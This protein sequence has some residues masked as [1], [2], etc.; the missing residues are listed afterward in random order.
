MYTPRRLEGA[1]NL[2]P[3]THLV[4][5]AGGPGPP[6]ERIED[7]AVLPLKRLSIPKMPRSHLEP[8]I[9]STARTPRSPSGRPS[10]PPGQGT[11][12]RRTRLAPVG[13]ST[14]PDWES[15]E[16]RGLYPRLGKPLLRV[17]LFIATFPV[18]L[19]IAIP[20]AIVN[21]ILFGSPRHIVYRQRRVGFR[22]RTFIIYKF[23]TLRDSSE[24]E[25]DA[26]SEG[27]DLTRVT[28]FGLFLRTTHLDELPQL[29]NILRGEM[30]FIGPRPEMLEIDRWARERIPN[31]RERN[32]LQPG[33]T[34]YAQ[35]THGYAHR[36]PAAYAR[37]L[38]ADQHYRRNLTLALDLTILMRTLIWMVRGRGWGLPQRTDP[39]TVPGM[40]EVL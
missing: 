1:A 38:W 18:A 13:P 14:T 29:W 16:P 17:A 34:G 10:A 39:S 5:A 37:K 25:F 30:D 36:D 19:L 35:V 3:D 31:F 11:R 32:A 28:R 33:V 6:A 7:L 8:A 9:D 2:R 23:R 26:W 15:L 21:A 4:T 22:G 20:I 24:A 12:G 40:D 27:N